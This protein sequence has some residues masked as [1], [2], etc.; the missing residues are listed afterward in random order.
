MTLIQPKLNWT[1]ADPINFES[2]FYRIEKN[3]EALYYFSR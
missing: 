1:D 3:I 2:V